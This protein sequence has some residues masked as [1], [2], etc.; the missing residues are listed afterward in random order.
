M[1]TWRM[2][3]VLGLGF[4]LLTGMPA[5]PASAHAMPSSIVYLDF[6]EDGV[7]A[8]L[9]LPLDRLEV[10]F[11][12]G[13]TEHPEDVPE[14][15]GTELSAYVESHI[16]PQTPE[17]EAWSVEVRSLSVQTQELQSEL[18][19]KV[20]MQ[21]PAG[22][23]VEKFTLGYDVIIRELLTHSIMVSVRSDWNGG[24]LS[25]H[26]EL[27]GT[28]QGSVQSLAVDRTGGSL[29]TGF[30]SVVALGIGHIAE[31]FDH[32]LFLLVLL[33]PAPLAVRSGRWDGFAGIRHSA[34]GLFKVATAFT[35]GHSLTLIAGALG[36]MP[37]PS[38]T[39]E[40]LI[41]VSILVSAVHALRPLFPGRE[42]LVAGGFGLV[43]GMAFASLITELGISP[44][45]MAL[46]LF[47]FNLG[48]ELMQLFVIA[49]TVPWLIVLCI[50][51]AYHP[52]RIAGALFAAVAATGWLAE[53][54]LGE[55]NGVASLADAAG[56]QA[57][58][59]VG[60]LA[61]TALGSVL[62]SWLKRAELLK[63]GVSG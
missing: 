8:E 26:P 44:W 39:V 53:R 14:A 5:L 61:C 32:L 52:V 40:I 7:E 43:H 27:L 9:Q 57:Y 47:G 45:R 37:L 16:H 60:L 23:S 42:V 12:Q 31:G 18:I 25:D 59:L 38:R 21:P 3:L 6:Q 51:R 55:P 1:R 54:T 22:A 58:W 56:G 35:A 29:W 49:I 33:L 15:Y 41:A 13:L 17:G 48:I 46:S 11:G 24:V 20:W 34:A 50:T 28:I 36:W 19:V 62:Y 4:V 10:A 63:R 30:R 2:L